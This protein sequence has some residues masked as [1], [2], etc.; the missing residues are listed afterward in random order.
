MLQNNKLYDCGNRKVNILH[1]QLRNKASN[2]NNDMYNQNMLDYPKY[3]C[4]AEMS[5]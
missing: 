4:G 5:I 3:M 1:W 2:L